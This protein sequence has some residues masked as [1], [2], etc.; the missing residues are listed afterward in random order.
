MLRVTF[1]H[2]DG[3]Y[4]VCQLAT[5]DGTKSIHRSHDLPH[6]VQLV[7]NLLHEH[8][9]ATASRTQTARFLTLTA[10]TVERTIIDIHRRLNRI[11]NTEAIRL[12]NEPRLRVPNYVEI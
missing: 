10:E 5:P 8:N 7:L 3:V 11:T 1:V 6:F 12:N 4:W 9:D 2:R